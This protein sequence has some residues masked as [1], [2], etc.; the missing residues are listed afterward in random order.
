VTS[1]GSSR[2]VEPSLREQ[3]RYLRRDASGAVRWTSRQLP[4]RSWTTL[5]RERW[6][7]I[8]TLG[9]FPGSRPARPACAGRDRVDPRDLGFVFRALATPLE[10]CRID[11]DGSTDS[12]SLG[13]A[14]LSPLR[15]V[16]PAASTPGGADCSAPPSDQGFQTPM[17]CSVLVV[18]HHLDGFLRCRPA[19]LLRP[20]GGRGVRGVVTRHADTLR[21]VP[22]A[23]S[24]TASLR[25]IPPCHHRLRSWLRGFSPLA[26]PLSLPRRCRRG[27]ARSSHGL[28]PLRG[29]SGSAPPGR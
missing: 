11:P 29:P 26:N 14:R 27:C 13:L 24:R 22:L 3:C 20:A 23:R 12:S 6:K 15:R 28:V 16:S 1:A 25:P 8:G 5:H 19:G 7:R 17:S 21:R 4:P 2:S 9:A 18:S 10:P